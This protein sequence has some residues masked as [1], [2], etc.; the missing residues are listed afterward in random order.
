M[1]MHFIIR[2]LDKAAGCNDR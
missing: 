1:K 2:H